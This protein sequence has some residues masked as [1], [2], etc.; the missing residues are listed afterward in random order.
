MNITFKWSGSDIT[1]KSNAPKAWFS[2]WLV[3]RSQSGGTSKDVSV[4]IDGTNIKI[5]SYGASMASG[6]SYEAMFYYFIA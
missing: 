3:L 5:R 4:N 1:I 2:S 6:S